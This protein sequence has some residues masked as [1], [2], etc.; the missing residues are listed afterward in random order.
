[1]NIRERYQE[2][3]ESTQ[4]GR[5]W[6]GEPIKQRLGEYAITLR[7]DSR[8]GLTLAIVFGED[9]GT[10]WEHARIVSSALARN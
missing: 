7:L 9:V 8:A 5:I 4:N 10:C 6:Q 2:R 1:M 3:H